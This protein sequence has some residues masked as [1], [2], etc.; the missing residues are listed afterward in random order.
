MMGRFLEKELYAD[1]A[2][3]SLGRFSPSFNK[4]RR[5]FRISSSIKSTQTLASVQGLIQPL[6]SIAYIFN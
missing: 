5:L 2:F 6:F 4:L 3:F 1:F